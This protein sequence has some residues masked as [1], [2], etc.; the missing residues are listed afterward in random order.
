[1]T[2]TRPVVAEVADF[3]SASSWLRSAWTTLPLA[4]VRL[5]DR[6][7]EDGS[8][9]GAHRLSNA[10]WRVLVDSPYATE[11]VDET[12][13]CRHESQD[14]ARRRAG[15]ICPTCGIYDEDGRLIAERGT[16]T[17]RRKR[18]RS[19]MSAALSTLSRDVAPPPGR[20]TGI[21]VIVA[22][23]WSGWDV[24]LTASW[25]GMP[26]VSSDHRETVRAL[27]LMHIR[28]L[29]SRYSSGPLPNIPKWIDLS[30]SQQRAIDAA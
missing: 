19:P 2:R 17:R 23:A 26:I 14:P 28:K 10:M 7:I 15:D 16:V 3:T 29:Y 6:D 27:I 13:D 8:Q 12:A 9:L 25:L 20:P 24:D 18:Y 4:P 22:Y 30:E 21:D 5:H 11:E 1:M